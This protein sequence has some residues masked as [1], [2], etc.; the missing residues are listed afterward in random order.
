M[1]DCAFGALAMMLKD[2]VGAA[3]DGGNTGISIGG[4]DKSRQPFIFV[5]FACGSWGGRPWSDGVQGNSNMF[6]NMASQSVELIES[7]NPLQIL[8]YE[9]IA[10][11]AGAGKYRGG[12][13]YRRDYRFTEE[14]AVLQVR[15]DRRRFRPYG[16]YGGRPGQPSQNIMNPG[17]GAEPLDSKLTM[18][19]RQGDVFRHEL[20]GGGG[21]GDPLERNPEHVL[22]DVRNEYVSVDGARRDYGVV[23]D[24]SAWSVDVAA[25]EKLR[26]SRSLARGDA[27]LPAVAWADE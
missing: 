26:K 22:A 10:D 5:D 6:A 4:Y 21:W 15:S 7:Q 13:P 25:T 14:E 20:A 18:T 2:E 19:F 27:T 17:N 8:R 9:L 24:D 12:V 1:G 16:L 11:R 23:I 3:S